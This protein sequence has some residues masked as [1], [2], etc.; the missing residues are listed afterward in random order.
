LSIPLPT[1]TPIPSPTVSHTPTPIPTSSPIATPT[2]ACELDSITAFPKKLTLNKEESDDVTITVTG[3]EGC[4][5][6]GEMVTA[7]VKSG[8]RRI[9]VTPLSQDTDA[10]GEAIFTITATEKT[11]NAK[12]KFETAGLKTTVTVKVKNK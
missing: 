12:V 7:T 2:P 10:N 6:V 5:A 4:P 9:S 11:G 3:N 8:K 1:P